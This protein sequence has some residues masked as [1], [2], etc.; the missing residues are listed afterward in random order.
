MLMMDLNVRQYDKEQLHP[1]KW[2][3]THYYMFMFSY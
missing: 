2:E 3:F 1:R